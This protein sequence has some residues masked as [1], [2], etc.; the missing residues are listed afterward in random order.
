MSIGE[1]LTQLRPDFPDISISKIRFLEAEGLVEPQRSASGYRRFTP[2]DVA[3]LRYVLTVQRDH[4]L[5][6]RVIKEQ[7][8]QLDHGM[9]LVADGERSITPYTAVSAKNTSEDEVV[10][11]RSSL[12]EAAGIGEELLRELE[13]YSL[14]R[15]GRGDVYDAH[16]LLVARTAGEL[17]G[18]GLEPRHLRSV[19]SSAERTVDLVEQVLTPLLRQRSAEAAGRAEEVATEIARL[20]TRLHAAFVDAGVRRLQSR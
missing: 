1:V 13:S 10:L 2:D 8:D 16:A 7:L 11:T 5:P 20:T 12:L 18:Y 17:A 3:R 9:E 14:V 6:L 4:Y 15:P 19:R